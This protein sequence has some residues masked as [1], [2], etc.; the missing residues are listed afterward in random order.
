MRPDIST[1]PETDSS[2]GIARGYVLDGPVSIPVT[3]TFFFSPQNE[4]GSGAHPVYYPMGTW[5]YFL[6]SK[7]AGA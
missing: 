1:F 6:G 7:A 4:T 5:S 2:V 3:A